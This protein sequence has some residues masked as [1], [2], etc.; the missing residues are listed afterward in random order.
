MREGEP[1]FVAKDVCD[2]LGYTAE[3]S[4]TLTKHVEDVDRSPFNL[5]TLSNREAIRGNPRVSIIN[6]SGLYSL[7]MGSKKPEAKAFKKWV[8]SVVLP[9]IRKDG[10]YVVG[11]EKVVS[12]EM[13]IEE[14]T[15]KV[16]TAMTAKVNRLTTEKAA[17]E[18]QVVAAALETL[19][20]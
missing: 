20:G 3:V 7:I 13:S 1:W 16:M 15:V 10:A 9:A 5:N 8:T 17:L 11:E 14:M 18:A 19:I 12:G 4:A 6:E 2:A